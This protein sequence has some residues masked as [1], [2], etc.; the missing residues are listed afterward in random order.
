MSVIK[1]NFTKIKDRIYL[2]LRKK[3]NGLY[4]SQHKNLA[5]VV[6][7]LR[8]R[9]YRNKLTILICAETWSGKVLLKEWNR[10]SCLISA[11]VIGCL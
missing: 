6:P 3:K 1:V 8:K 11:L 2:V 10:N 4:N 9:I 7:I 5:F